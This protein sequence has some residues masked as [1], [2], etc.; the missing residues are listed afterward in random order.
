MNQILP[1]P[2]LIVIVGPT[3]VGKTAVAIELAQQ[4]KTEIVSADSRQFYREMSIGTAKPNTEE[5]AAAKHHFIGSIPITQNFSVGDFEKEGLVVL[6]HIFKDHDKAIL[7]GGSGLYIKAICEGF[8]DLPV[9][10]PEIRDRLNKE[11]MNTA[12]CT[13][14]KN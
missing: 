14:R 2:T 4:L 13:C 12:L 10:S 9:A 7:V 11:F 5:L 6:D 1:Q 8:D 3:A